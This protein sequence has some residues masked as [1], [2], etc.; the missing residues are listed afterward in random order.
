MPLLRLEEISLAYGHIPLLAR[1]NLQIDDGER[2]CLVGR[3]GAGKTTLLRVIT[4]AVTPDEGDIWRKDTLRVAHLEQEVPPDTDQTIFEVV[5]GGLGELGSLL[6]EYHQMTH[7]P[8]ALDRASLRG[9]AELQ[10][11]IETLGGWNINQK[12][13]TVLTRLSLPGDKRLSDCSGGIRRQVMLARA[14]VCEPDL[15]LLDEPTN[16]LDINAIIWLESYLVNFQG[17]LI[18]ITHDRSFVRRLATRIVELDRGKLISF[19]GNYDTYLRKKDELLE[20]EE[21]AIAKFDKKL[22]EEEAWIR[23]GIKAR[24]TRNEG[25]VRA[26]HALR[27]EKAQRL[28]TQN[29][30]RF[31]IDAGNLSGKLVVDVRRVSF[32]YDEHWIV[33]DW[34]VRILRR[35]RVG[36]LGPNGSGKSTLLKLILGELKPTSGEVVLGT[37]LQVVYFDQHRRMLDLEK[38]VRENL[39]DS[40]YVT[41]KG[42]SRHVIGYLKDFLFAPDR[43]DSPV[44]SLSGGERNR[45]LLAKIFTRSANMIVLDEPT[46][47]LDVDT[48]ELLEDLLA[49]YEGTL[50]LV[51]HDRT[52]LDNVVTSTLVFEGD[53]KFGEYAGGYEDWERYQR[54]IPPFA[55]AQKAVKVNAQENAETDKLIGTP[56][57]LTYKEQRE[58]QNLPNRIEALEAE[59]GEL[60]KLMAEA[61][62]Y[63]QPGDKI[64][65]SIERL[66][67]V[68]RELEAC[69]ERWQFLE[70]VAKRASY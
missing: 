9:L 69:Y 12:V 2:V 32:R 4:G 42:R 70:S 7:G 67:T 26:L 25:R 15:L 54:P 19:P 53:G 36:V 14:L 62:F 38:T 50:L 11:R 49:D 30:A 61:D 59:Q 47:D 58:R 24:R 20:I 56:R 68:K 27:R 57:K 31:G 52:F 43:I 48:L 13:A 55:E 44:K 40:D 17:A 23:Q 10:T 3:N 64:A 6:T 66:E 34:S 8:D 18:F 28:E 51:S 41:V 21:R 37:R 45:L 33:R 1:V 5:A 63:R 39:S 60:H 22:A 35:E 29:K 46:N 65:A 16:H